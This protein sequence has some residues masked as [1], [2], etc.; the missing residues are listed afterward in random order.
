MGI[1]RVVQFQFKSDIGSDAIDKV[2]AKIQ[3]LRK[4][5]LHPE[6]KKP[7]IQSIQGGAD[8]A[9]EGLQQGITH[10]FVIQFDS[11]EDR[12]YYALKDPVHLA[13]VAEL[14]PLVEKV[15]IIDLPRND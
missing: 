11:P 2:S 5:C 7:Y 15:Q 4:T 8:S 12:D 10:A 14:G 1:N 13:V 3:G 9:P 6:S